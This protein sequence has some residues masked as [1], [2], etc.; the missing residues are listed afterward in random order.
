M[1]L[2]FGTVLSNDLPTR[3][4]CWTPKSAIEE[5]ITHIHT[6]TSDK[7]KYF[8]HDNHDCSRIKTWVC[9]WDHTRDHWKTRELETDTNGTVVSVCINAL[10][11]IASI[12]L[13][14]F[15]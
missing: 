5:N 14:T 9:M 10:E 11:D 15:F 1:A 13:T 6:T 4:S 8:C 7:M 3:N 2:R 12:K